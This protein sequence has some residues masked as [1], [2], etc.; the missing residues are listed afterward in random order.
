M[1][2]QKK[3]RNK[4]FMNLKF[5]IAFSELSNKE[6]NVSIHVNDVDFMTYH[7][8]ECKAII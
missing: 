4:A 1:V 7:L 2:L 8:S 6:N 3:K 5:K